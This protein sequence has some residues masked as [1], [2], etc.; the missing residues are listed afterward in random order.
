MQVA[1]H[2]EQGKPL[3]EHTL[4]FRYS[5]LERDL[6]GRHGRHRLGTGIQQGLCN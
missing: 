2:D 1:E 3:R 4:P 5:M 6:S